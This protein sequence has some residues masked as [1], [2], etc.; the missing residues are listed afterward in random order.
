[1]ARAINK[2]HILDELRR[3]A[4]SMEEGLLAK[5]NLRTI[6]ELTSTTGSRIIGCDGVMLRKRL[7]FPGIDF[8]RPSGKIS[9]SES[10]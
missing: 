2:Q 4:K 6:R 10:L 3:I 7:V 8:G 9:S 1:V 5:M